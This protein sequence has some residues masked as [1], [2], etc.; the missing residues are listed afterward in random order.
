MNANLPRWQLTAWLCGLFLVV[1]GAKLWVVQLYG[2]GLPVWDQWPEAE[3]LFRPWIEGR[4]TWN[5][6]F[7]PHNEHRIFFTRLLDLAVIRLNG[8]W[9][10]LLQMTI[11]ASLHAA[12]GCVL[13]YCLWNF[14]GRKNAGQICL[15]LL[16]LL[17]LPFAAENI[18]RGFHSQQYFL[19][20]G[21]LLTLLGLGFA[22]L[23]SGRW[24]FG[25][26][27]SGATLFTMGS[28][29]LAPLTVA[30]LMML[31]T[32]NVKKLS[33]ANT[34]TLGASLGVFMIGMTLNVGVPAHQPYQ[35]KSLM[36][37]TSAFARNLAWP[38]LDQP[39]LAGVVCLPLVLLA[40]LY[41]RQNFS[42]RPAAEFLL[43]LGLWG[44]LQ[45]AAL[46]YGRANYDEPQAS[47]YQDALSGVALAALFSTVFLAEH[48]A[49]RRW[50]G[51]A[52]RLLPFA[53][54][55]LIF[56]GVGHVSRQT[57]D[58][59]LA[60]TRLDNL[61][62]E[63]SVRAFMVTD[64]AGFLQDK[65]V[66]LPDANLTLTLLRDKKLSAIMPSLCQSA[67][68]NRKSSTSRLSADARELGRHAPA[69]LLAGLAL[70]VG[71]AGIEMFGGREAFVARLP[72][73]VICLLAGSVAIALVWPERQLDVVAVSRDLH[74][75]LGFHFMARGDHQ[76]AA[77][78]F[79]AALRL[80][81]DESKT[82]N[83]A[84]EAEW[85]MRT[86]QLA[87]ENIVRAMETG[88]SNRVGFLSEELKAF[89]I[90]APGGS[91]N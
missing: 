6:W 52:A 84:P 51:W 89:R 55:G 19:S 11:N 7:A 65:L 58:F 54:A 36:D 21:S 32:L 44:V 18:I 31:R 57:V 64:D 17:A 13:A 67:V 66:P 79:T 29:L 90:R 70:F 10:P 16:P 33:R 43:G 49:P 14:L 87:Q 1:L 72:G 37:F 50:P 30:G 40:V 5:S 53:F 82:L 77:L 39:A 8:Q 41:F 75:T 4:L 24:W 42:N 83:P 73:N 47:R 12:Y 3:Q 23:G 45:S 38:F 20:L 60:S 86:L 76:Q 46:A 15:L 71:L 74:R 63:E 9:D 61:V 85:F 69:I 81:A 2:S 59:F 56:F 27:A 22:P 80:A 48:F 35:A 91:G 78:Q 68:S 28:G 88:D 25:L 62:E 26:A 34:I